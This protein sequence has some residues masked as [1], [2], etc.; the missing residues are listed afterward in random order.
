MFYWTWPQ[1]L[2]KGE[3]AT[4][5]KEQLLGQALPPPSLPMTLA[6]WSQRSTQKVKLPIPCWADGLRFQLRAPQTEGFWL[7]RLAPEGPKA[8]S[9]GPGAFS[10]VSSFLRWTWG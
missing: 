5:P 3:L 6:S 10:R 2:V 4:S 9:Q 1:S 7:P 8:T